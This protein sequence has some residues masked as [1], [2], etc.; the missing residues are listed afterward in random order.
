MYNIN[1]P[2]FPEYIDDEY[3]H[4]SSIRLPAFAGMQIINGSYGAVSEPGSS[5]GDTHAAV[6][7]KH[8]TKTTDGT[9]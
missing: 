3:H 6:L 8:L 7:I 9:N 2:A 4:V 5:T 1:A